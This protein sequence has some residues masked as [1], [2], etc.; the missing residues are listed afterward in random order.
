[1]SLGNAC[2]SEQRIPRNIFAMLRA[3]G[4]FGPQNAEARTRP[5]LNW[6]AE[7]RE[8]LWAEAT[9]LEASGA[10]IWLD[11]DAVRITATNVQA[12]RLIED[13]WEDKIS[14]WVCGKEFVCVPDIMEHALSLS[15]K[16]QSKQA[17]MRVAGTLKMLGW[18]KRPAWTDEGG[19]GEKRTRRGWIAP[20]SV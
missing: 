3:T 12:D 13:A 8:Q 19:N 14:A 2:S 7:N 4:E 15:I 18:R 5:T 10:T 16:D 6:L 20:D 1:M 17:Q 9:H 11:D